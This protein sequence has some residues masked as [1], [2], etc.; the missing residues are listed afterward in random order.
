MIL[1]Q[2]RLK[3]KIDLIIKKINTYDDGIEFDFGNIKLPENKITRS[4]KSIGSINNW[5]FKSNSITIEENGWK[6]NR[7]IF[8]NDPFD[9]HQISFEGIDVIA[10]EDEDGKLLITSSKTNLILENRTKIFLGKRIFGKKR[11]KK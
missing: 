6:S 10:E 8:T 11:K 3:F 5:R 4:N 9:P 2:I 1:I 7:I